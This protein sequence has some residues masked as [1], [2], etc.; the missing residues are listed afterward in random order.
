M[1]PLLH[2][3]RISMIFPKEDPTTKA[4]VPGKEP[5]IIPL[6]IPGLAGPGTIATLTVLSHQVGPFATSAAFIIAWVPSLFLLLAASYIKKMLGEKGLI[7]VEK[8]G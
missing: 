6:A 7:A 5:M 1:V 8:L 3:Q 4:D 2:M